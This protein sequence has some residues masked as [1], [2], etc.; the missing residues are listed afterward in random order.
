MLGLRSCRP[1]L[2]AARKFPTSYVARYST[3]P[4]KPTQP[5]SNPFQPAAY[6]AYDDEGSTTSLLNNLD[7]GLDRPPTASNSPFARSTGLPSSF[8]SKPAQYKLYLQSTKTNTITTLTNDKNDAVACI[9][10]G[11]CGFKRGQ[12]SSY[13]A[14]Y[15][16]A[17]KI[18]QKVE[19]A[20]KRE[21]VR[22]DLYLKGFGSGREA[23]QKALLTTEGEN[24]R[25]LI[26]HVI[27]MTPLKI[28][29]TRA[30]KARRL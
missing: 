23:M 28:G 21:T 4:T 22:V 7:G 26:T 9:S 3:P 19:E 11:S 27:D 5:S 12:R 13:E 29:G 24:V 1:S 6:D 20:A 2:L 10:A 18:F 17:I 16:C 30:K 8:N 14:G 15:Q 25:P